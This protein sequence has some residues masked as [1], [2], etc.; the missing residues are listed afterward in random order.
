MVERWTWMYE[1]RSN[2]LKMSYLMHSTKHACHENIP[3]SFHYTEAQ[4][5]KSITPGMPAVYDN[6]QR[7]S[8]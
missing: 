7:K 8:V 6:T 3:H 4:S 5:S 2:K 1:T